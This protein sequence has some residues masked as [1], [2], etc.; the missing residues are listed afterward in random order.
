MDAFVYKGDAVRGEQ[1]RALFAEEAP[2]IDFRLWPETGDPAEVR[3]LASWQAPSELIAEFPN[4]EALFSLGAGVD[5]FNL[6]QLPEQVSLVRLVD[7][8]IIAGIVEYAIFAVLALHRDIP[9]YLQ[10][11]REGVWRERKLTP[12]AERRVGVLG[13]G[14][15]GRAVLEA[16]GPFGFKLH[17]WSRSAKTLDGVECFCGEGGLDALLARAD[18]LVC[19]LP[20][21]PDTRGIINREAFAKLPAGARLV[22]LGRG[23]HVVQDDLLAALDEGRVSAAVLDVAS[24]EPLPPGHPFYSDPRIILTPH[25][26]AMTHP[27]S[28]ARVVIANLR[29]AQAGLPFEGLVPLDRGY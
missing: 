19:L 7:P 21:T 14:E 2:D 3:W 13:L 23:G 25:I 9:R 11:Q 29:R 4:L 18:I 1:W 10:D 24:P 28:A 15:L 5:Q 16:L 26:A 6:V 17:G 22:N 20:L 12:A 8:G 27:Q